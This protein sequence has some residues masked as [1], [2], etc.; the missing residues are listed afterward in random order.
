[1]KY[2]ELLRPL[3]L[4]DLLQNESSV[5]CVEFKKWLS[6]GSYIVRDIPTN[7]RV[8]IE[9]NNEHAFHHMVAFDICRM[10]SASFETMYNLRDV[11]LLP[12]SFAWIAIKSY[13][14]AFF[15]AHSI[16]RCFGYICSQLE[17]GHVL[18]IN[19]YG[20][21]IGLTNVVKPE[22]GFFSGVY[23]SSSRILFLDK[24]KN[25]HEDT[26]KT[27]VDCLTKVSQDVLNVTALKANKQILSASITEIIEKITDRGRLS[28]GN[29]LSQFRNSV[30]YRHDY[31]SWHPY[32]KRSIK[33]EKIISLLSKWNFEGDSS[34]PIWKESR[35]AYDFFSACKDVVNFNHSLIQV[36]VSNANSDK[37]LFK[38]WPSKLLS[39]MNA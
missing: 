11:A 28:N 10:S 7:K 9:V 13:Y 34:S 26:W 31:D 20:Q 6:S 36:L 16:M 27:L 3:L 39:I 5:Y 18:Q 33:S 23:D 22:S 21:I 14:A 38:R 1:M 30:N 8:E 24:M 25:T 15:S 17:K 29:Y 2:C 35:E 12:K 37:N 4:Q 19:S 32:G